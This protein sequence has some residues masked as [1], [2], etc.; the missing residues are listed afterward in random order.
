VA[1]LFIQAINET[2]APEAI[3]NLVWSIFV[4][5]SQLFDAKEMLE[6]QNKILAK[7]I[8]FIELS[9]EM[10][11]VSPEVESSRQGFISF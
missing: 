6:L 2:E 4:W 1:E 9:R 8:D 5:W 10:K 11:N 3:A 7:K